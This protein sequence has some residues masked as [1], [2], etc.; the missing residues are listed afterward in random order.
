MSV[1]E[2]AALRGWRREAGL[3]FVSRSG[4]AVTLREQTGGLVDL[5]FQTYRELVAEGF[6]RKPDTS[7][8]IDFIPDDYGRR[9]QEMKIAAIGRD[10]E[11]RKNGN[12]A[13]RA[14]EILEAELRDD[15][16]HARFLPT[17]F[18]L[19]TLQIWKRAL[20][21]EGPLGLLPRNQDQGHRGPRHDAEFEECVLYVL[22]NLLLKSDRVTVG[23]ASAKA[24]KLYRDKCAERGVTP[25]A[26]SK[27]SFLSVLN[28]LREDD[29]IKARHNRETAKKLTLQ[30]Q[31]YARVQFPFDLV[32]I[33][34]TTAD[35]FLSNINGDCIGRPIICAAIDAATGYCLGLRISLGAADE[36][37]T[38]QTI[39]EV[40]Q[41]RDEAFYKTYGIENRINT[42]GVPQILVSDQGSENSGNWLPGIIAQSGMEWGKN[43]PGCPEKKPHVE[44]FFRELNRFLHTIPGATTS[45][46]MPN[47]QRI[48]KGM[49]EACLTIEDLEKV[50]YQ[51]VYNEYPRMLRRMIHS[52]LRVAESPADSWTR[53]AKGIA[54]LPLQPEEVHQIFMVEETTRRLQHYGIDVRNVQ[55]FSDELGELIS[56][57]GRKAPV[58]V[59]FDP[60]DIRAIAVVHDQVGIPSP[61]I[62]PAKSKDVLPIGFDD[63]SRIKK[64]GEEAKSEDLAARASAA[65]L[66]QHAQE[67]AEQR[68][69]GK[70]SSLK[71]ARQKERTRQKTTQMVEQAKTPPLQP[72]SAV[73]TINQPTPRMPVRRREQSPQMDHLE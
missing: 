51:W 39:K 32:E 65:D 41:P 17:K 4:D 24:E 57:V 20:S 40:M 55:Y 6:A 37:L 16:R 70:R 23:V 38:V 5:N 71:R 58:N 42:A 10:T 47:R 11:L 3:T 66:A 45:K 73:N 34:S 52:P 2:L 30:A 18:N 26:C 33:D 13:A 1:T 28:T 50:V 59:R 19:R 72:F 8:V 31:F 62:V 61:M 36:K 22:E 46:S 64:P 68:D 29:I 63:V 43:I 48:G 56:T 15:P 53:L 35:V 12:T 21:E 60:N 25:K 44:R 69:K 54:H 27:K 67:L 49:Q 7:N 14:F 9:K